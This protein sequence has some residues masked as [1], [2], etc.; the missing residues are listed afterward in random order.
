MQYCKQEINF[1]ERMYKWMER[2][3]QR[4][5]THESQDAIKRV[6]TSK[7]AE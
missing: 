5:I 4:I 7:S 6:L 3:W 2:K 1:F